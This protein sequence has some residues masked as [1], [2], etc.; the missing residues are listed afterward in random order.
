MREEFINFLEEN[1]KQDLVLLD[2]SIFNREPNKICMCL[3]NGVLFVFNTDNNGFIYATRTF[4]TKIEAY[5]NI[6][7][8][9][10]LEYKLGKQKVK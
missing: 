2:A 4:N 5:Q 3:Y 6:A 7:L 8:R 10:G 9:L 1:E